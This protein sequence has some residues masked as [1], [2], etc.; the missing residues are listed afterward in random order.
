MTDAE[1]GAEKLW[2]KDTGH[3]YELGKAR[4]GPPEGTRTAKTGFSLVSPILDF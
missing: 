3:L 2:A 1:A 4:D